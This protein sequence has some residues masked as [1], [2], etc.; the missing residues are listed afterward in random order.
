LLK[1]L[2]GVLRAGRLLR[3]QGILTLSVAAKDADRDEILQYI[4]SWYQRAACCQ[5]LFS[6]N[7]RV[8]FSG[9]SA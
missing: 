3:T 7:T 2:F 8:Y 4:L 9:Q 1:N 6:G 5:T